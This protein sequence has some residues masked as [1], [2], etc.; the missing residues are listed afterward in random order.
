MTFP[1]VNCNLTISYYQAGYSR[2]GEGAT[3]ASSIKDVK[4]RSSEGA[5]SALSIKGAKRSKTQKL[6]STKQAH[7]KHTNKKWK[8]IKKKIH[9]LKLKKIK[10]VARKKNSGS[11]ARQ[12]VCLP[13]D[14]YN[15]FEDVASQL[16]NQVTNSLK[17]IKRFN[18]FKRKAG[19]ERH[20]LEEKVAVFRNFRKFSMRHN[21]HIL[22]IIQV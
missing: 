19:K 13:T 15:T 16:Q 12:T 1:K 8:K 18:N 5:T 6:P 14:C 2:L 3:S 7:N 22:L 17:R 9:Q 4:R 10:N 11:S 21:F 20:Q